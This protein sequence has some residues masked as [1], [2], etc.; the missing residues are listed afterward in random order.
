M[1]TSGIKNS[2]KF[3]IITDGEP[4]KFW[5]VLDDAIVGMGFTSLWSTF[6]LPEWLMMMIAHIVVLIG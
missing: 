4:Q 6:K 5:R 3:Y 2:G 1:L